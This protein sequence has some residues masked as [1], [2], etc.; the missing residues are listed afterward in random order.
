MIHFCAAKRSLE[1]KCSRHP[2]TGTTD[3]AKFSV[4]RIG[5]RKSDQNCFPLDSF[6]MMRPLGNAKSV[7]EAQRAKV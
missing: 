5:H 6:D 2:K 7:A 3:A 1:M 4:H